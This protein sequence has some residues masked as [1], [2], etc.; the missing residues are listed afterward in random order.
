MIIASIFLYTPTTVLASTTDGT[1]SSTYRYAWGE[2]AGWVDFGSTAGNVHITDSALTGSVYG[3][4]IGWITLNPQ[5]YGGVINNAEGA[6]SGYAWGENVGWID[7]SKVTIGSDG[8]FAG[9]AYG[10][11]IGWITFGTGNNKVSTDWRPSS[12]RTVAS[13]PAPAA[14]TASSGGGGG[15]GAG[16]VSSPL[17]ASNVSL[18]LKVTP[19]STSLP[20]SGGSITYTYA[21]SNTG[22]A[23][24]LGVSVTDTACSPASYISGDTNG[25]SS[26]NYNSLYTNVDGVWASRNVNEVWI[27]RCTTNLSK[28]TENTA[29][30]TGN[31]Q[32]FRTEATSRSLVTVGALALITPLAPPPV[33]TTPASGLTSVQAN[34]ILSLLSSFGA[35]SAVIASVRA[36]LFEVGAGANVPV[37]I[38]GTFT[39]DLDLGAR[40]EDVRALQDFLIKRG[41]GFASGQLS[42]VGT[43]GYF[44]TLTQ[45]A[46]KE[47]QMANGIT[48]AI[49]YFGPK[50]RNYIN[51]LT[52]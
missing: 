15:G 13:T 3:E 4:N 5:T 33:V 14:S 38:T 31:A 22:T 23:P 41:T 19:S 9:N 42:V 43:S 30:A 2:N 35:D 17:V 45:T 6:L 20:A 21:V 16:S 39:H 52:P 49:G 27:F 51:N 48:P 7:F 37:T 18:S 11:N 24:I 25:D 32:G 36:V 26:I 29:T 46:L 44:G 12:T 40:G 1:I 47:F 28:T 34:A 8:V 50:T 10:E